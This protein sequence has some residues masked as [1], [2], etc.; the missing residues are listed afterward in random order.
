MLYIWAALGLLLYKASGCTGY[1][2][3]A[4]DVSLA[5]RERTVSAGP[6]GE[7]TGTHGRVARLVSFAA[8]SG[9]RGRAARL[10]TAGGR[11]R[12]TVAQ[13]AGS[14]YV[15]RPWTTLTRPSCRSSL[16]ARRTVMRD[17]P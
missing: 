17:T 12:P 7:R 4:G 10:A 16:M 13:S 8:E 1:V 2:R 5:L 11:R 3:S 15:P 9:D 6:T 14:A